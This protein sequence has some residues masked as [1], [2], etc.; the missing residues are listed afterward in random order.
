MRCVAKKQQCVYI[1]TTTLHI[2]ITTTR[3]ISAGSPVGV[4]LRLELA[5]Q[6][7][8][9]GMSRRLATHEF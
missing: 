6:L 3:S 9:T 1:A 8:L 4:E 7:T 2:H 5:D